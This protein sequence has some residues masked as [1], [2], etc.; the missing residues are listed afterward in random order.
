MKTMQN[1]NHTSYRH[2]LLAASI[3][4]LSTVMI[5]G[6]TAQASDIDI[7]QQARSGNITL[8]MLFDISGSMGAP[9]LT[10]D[11]SACDV[12]SHISMG[13]SGTETSTNGSP[14]YTRYYCQVTARAYKYRS[15]RNGGGSGTHNRWQKCEND[16]ET[17]E[18][19]TWGDTLRHDLYL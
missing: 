18:G 6:T 14:T 13:T 16:A 11:R 7:Y 5:T 12:P 2:K 8:M 9:Q 19:C 10:N 15:W 3:A 4:A 17:K 1:K